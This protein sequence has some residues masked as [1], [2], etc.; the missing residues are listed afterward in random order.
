VLKVMRLGSPRSPLDYLPCPRTRS[1]IKRGDTSRAPHY[2]GAW[3]HPE[4]ASGGADSDSLDRHQCQP[5]ATGAP[6]SA[7][8]CCT[9][10]TRQAHESSPPVLLVL[11]GGAANGAATSLSK[12]YVRD[13][14]APGKI[15][16][17]ST[18]L[19]RQQDNKEN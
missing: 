18:T 11:A 10:R 15:D 8:T 16:R 4:H 1:R 13:A 2:D 17:S 14:G 7:E 12:R 3:P 9:R 19:R 6:N 5:R